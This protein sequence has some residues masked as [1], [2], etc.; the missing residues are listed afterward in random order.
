LVIPLVPAKVWFYLPRGFAVATL[1][2]SAF[3]KGFRLMER[4]TKRV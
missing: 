2:F 3:S 4:K 1:V